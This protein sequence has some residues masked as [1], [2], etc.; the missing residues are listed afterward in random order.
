MK[1]KVA[2]VTGGASGIGLATVCQLADDGAEVVIADNVGS[3]QAADELGKAGRQSVYG[4]HL[5]VSNEESVDRV[6]KDV[7]DKFGRVDFL[8]TAAGLGTPRPTTIDKTTIEEWSRLVA[9]NLTGTFLSCRAAIPIMRRT[10]GAIV[11]VGSELGLIGAANCAMY[12]ATKGGVVQ[13][14]R[15]LAVDHAIDGIRVNCVCPGPINTPML[16]RS[17]SRAQD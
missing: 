6:F 15:A 16:H 10:G 1:S 17:A 4:L 2:V 7:D 3:Q 9:V 5:D 14:T 11:L 13:M 8:V 12:S